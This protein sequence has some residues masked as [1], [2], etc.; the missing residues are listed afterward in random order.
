MD[1]SIIPART[2]NLQ[3]SYARFN[4]LLI[5]RYLDWLGIRGC[6]PNT[7]R[8]YRRA[9]QEFVRFLGGRS[10]LTVRHAE[11]LEYLAGIYDR[12]V[13]KSSVFVYVEALRSFAKY[14][15]LRELP[16]SGALA[17]LTPPKFAPKIG[18]FHSYEEIE[19]LIAGA[20]TPLERVIVEM[21][22]GTGCRISELPPI[23]VEQI[24]WSNRTLTV[25]AKG[26]K[27]HEVFFGKPAEEAL[28]ALLNGRTQGFIFRPFDSREHPPHLSEGQPNKTINTVYWRAHWTEYDATG[29]GRQRWC[30]LGKQSELSRDE[31]LYELK[32]RLSHS[33]LAPPP[34]ADK[35][36]SVRRIAGILSAI[37]ARVGLKTHC[38]KLR[39]SF[40]TEMLKDGAGIREIQELLGHASISTTARYLHLAIADLIE[41]HRKYHPHETE[42]TNGKANV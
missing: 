38:H 13:A 40:A 23:R 33:K 2:P 1:Q 39:H 3:R 8:T 14:I 29:K 30:W 7:L 17:R 12:G 25:V 24:D 32:G 6:S 28:R 37:G 31:A 9:L 27:E 26:H 19:R 11:L 16:N 18:D 4:Q 36:L 15:G 42:E 20:Q 21:Y 41:T 35:P 34:T 22:F 5:R 10:V